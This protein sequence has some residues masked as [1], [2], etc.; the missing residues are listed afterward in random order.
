MK[1]IIRAYH[2]VKVYHENDNRS[3]INK[4]DDLSK[5]TCNIHLLKFLVKN[6]DALISVMWRTM[7][8]F[9]AC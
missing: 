8:D 6:P 3:T 5:D 9:G 7:V 1:Y 4:V 2:F